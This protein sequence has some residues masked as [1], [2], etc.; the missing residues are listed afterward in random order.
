MRLDD[1]TQKEVDK[2]KAFVARYHAYLLSDL[3]DQDLLAEMKADGVLP[4]DRQRVIRQRQYDRKKEEEDRAL[5]QGCR[6]A[7][8]L[9]LGIIVAIF[10]LAAIIGLTR[11][12]VAR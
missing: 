11:G 8:L 10:A 12:I 5:K 3:N 7:G 4:I 2:I 9:L 1:E 6:Q